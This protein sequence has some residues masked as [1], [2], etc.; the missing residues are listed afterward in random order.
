MWSCIPFP[1]VVGAKDDE[2]TQ[3]AINFF[4]ELAKKEDITDYEISYSFYN[5]RG[6]LIE[7]CYRSGF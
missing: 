3:E 4:K 7:E 6:S 1:C 5:N 2:L